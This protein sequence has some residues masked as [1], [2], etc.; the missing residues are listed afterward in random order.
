M[1]L[2]SWIV[3]IFS[4]LQKP[5]AAS[6]PALD[7]VLAYETQSLAETI[8]RVAESQVGRGEADIDGD[9]RVDNNRG[10]AVVEYQKATWLPPGAWP[11]CAAFV[12]WVILQALS[13]LGLSPA[14]KRPRTAGAYDFEQ[15]AVGKYGEMFKAW[16]V[17]R[18]VAKDKSTWPRRGDI[19]TFTWS[20]IGIVTGFNPRTMLTSTV[21]GNA[22][23]D[24]T[25]DTTTGDH[26]VAKEHRLIK[27]RKLIRHVG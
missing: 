10:P 14:W 15:W 26:V 8:A 6:A 20:H 9:G 5:S 12:C 2:F 16:K 24:A 23:A 19:V 4:R 7:L 21:E 18:P 27:L 1:S 3:Q 25:S 22:G 17:V 11:W 13:S